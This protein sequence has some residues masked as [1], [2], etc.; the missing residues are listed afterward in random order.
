MSGWFATLDLWQQIAVAWI[1]C[2]FANVFMIGFMGTSASTKDLLGGFI[3]GPI[4][5]V[6][7]FAAIVSGFLRG[8]L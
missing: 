8:L 2:G 7:F 3:A 5:T 6:A 4:L 1:G